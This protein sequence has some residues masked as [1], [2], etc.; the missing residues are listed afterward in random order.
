MSD[1]FCAVLVRCCWIAWL[2]FAGCQTAS[3]QGPIYKLQAPEL[4]APIAPVAVSITDKRPAQERNYRRGGVQPAEYQDGIETLTL[5]NFEPQ[6]TEMLKEM[7][8]QRLSTLSLPPVWADVEVTRF[9]AL[10]DRREIL[11]VEYE[12]QLMQEGMTPAVGVGVGFGG[13]HGHGGGGS[14]VGAVGSGLIAMAVTSQRLKEIEEQ[15]SSWDHAF[16][17]VTCEIELHVELH[18]QDGRR[19]VFDLQAKSHSL[20]PTDQRFSDLMNGMKWNIPA[21]VEQAVIQISDKLQQQGA[22]LL[23]STNG[24]PLSGSRSAEKPPLHRD[25]PKRDATEEG[26][27]QLP[28]GREVD[29]P[30]S[31][32]GAGAVRL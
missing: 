7:F 32:Q 15:R 4:Q 10:I 14:V 5:E 18:W 29:V 26:Y 31:N 9:R 30:S 23:R 21:T 1:C 28:P 22:S 6:V 2:A 3:K 17:G 19:E 11:A 20:P 16:E 24:A 13:G 27:E 12:R 8:A 25:V